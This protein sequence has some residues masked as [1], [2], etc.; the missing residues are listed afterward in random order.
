[1][2]PRLPQLLKLLAADPAD[3]FVLYGIAQEHARA[4][5]HA[6]AVGFY[7]RCLAADPLYCYGYYHK[8]VSLLALGRSDDARA[9]LIAGEAAARDA[10]DGKALNEISGL[11]MT[12]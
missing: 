12:L 8:A 7:D 2:T 5:D 11:L 3:P 1:M 10:G 6:A 4:G 9:T